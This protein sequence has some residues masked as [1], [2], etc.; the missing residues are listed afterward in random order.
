LFELNCRQSHDC[1]ALAKDE[2][3]EITDT[4]H[5]KFNCGIDSS[6]HVHEELH[7]SR[8][9]KGATT[10]GEGL[11]LKARKKCF[12]GTEP[13]KTEVCQPAVAGICTDI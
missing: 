10:I 4:K 3:K 11:F 13:E 12:F 7:N 5:L 1:F 8:S 9:F 2:S 6:F